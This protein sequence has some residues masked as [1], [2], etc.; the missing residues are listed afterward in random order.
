MSGDVD[1]GAVGCADHTGYG[2]PYCYT[3]DPDTCTTDMPSQAHPGAEWR[4]CASLATPTAG[5]ETQD[6]AP[7]APIAPSAT[8]D[9]TGTGMAVSWNVPFNDGGGTLDEF[10]VQWSTD[11]T[12]LDA[13]ELAQA[14]IFPAPEEQVLLL[15]SPVTNEA[16]VIRATAK[17]VNEVQTIT[18]TVNAAEDD[19]VQTITT[20]SSS[21]VAEIQTVTTSAI[22]RDEVQQVL[23]SATLLPEIQ[24]VSMVVPHRD[25]I[26]VV[27]I[28]GTDVNEV[29]AITITTT[30]GA[31]A[32][33]GTFT[34][35]L[36]SS[37]P[38][39]DVA[40]IPIAVREEGCCLCAVKQPVTGDSYSVS[41]NMGSTAAQIEAALEGLTN[42]DAVTVTNNCEPVSADCTAADP[43][44]GGPS[45][46]NVGTTHTM[47]EW[48]VTFDGAGVNGD[49]PL[50]HVQSALDGVVTDVGN[51]P[52]AVE[53]V[54]GNEIMGMVRLTLNDDIPGVQT[55][56]EKMGSSGVWP[57]DPAADG[58][59]ESIQFNTEAMSG[60]FA[61]SGT[62]MQEKLEQ[63][64]FF[65]TVTVSRLPVD[66]GDAAVYTG[67]YTFAIT[68]TYKEGNLPPMIC[69]SSSLENKNLDAG[70]P[71]PT[72]EVCTHADDLDA[73]NAHHCRNGNFANGS[74]KLTHVCRDVAVDGTAD[75]DVACNNALASVLTTVAI[76]WDASEADVKTALQAIAYTNGGLGSVAVTRTAIN[77]SPGH[78]WSGAYA[79]A[80]TYTTKEGNVKPLVVSEYLTAVTAGGCLLTNTGLTDDCNVVSV[81]TVVETRDG[82]EVAGTVV[83]TFGAE[84]TADIA[85]TADAATIRSRLEALSAIPN[86]G[87]TVTLREDGAGTDYLG[88]ARGRMW[89]V[90]F[91]DQ[92]QGGNI[93][94]MSAV[95]TFHT[96]SGQGVGAAVG[97][98]TVKQG[99][100]L[101]GNFRLNYGDFQTGDI[102]FNANVAH[103]RNAL[104]LLDAIDTV[105][106]SVVDMTDGTTQVQAYQW[107][108]TFNWDH[109]TDTTRN[110]Y[111]PACTHDVTQIHTV[112]N[113]P[114]S[115]CWPRNVGDI[116]RK[117][118]V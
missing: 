4:D 99:C 106:V 66:S 84:S 37:K 57:G 63:S 41:L 73:T 101:T 72:C 40:A 10:L 2:S 48:R 90:T 112:P 111:D 14:S 116:D 89:L 45:V 42:I 70:T 47:Y 94:Q 60:G 117:S 16:Q 78:S 27:R 17:V 36:D 107:S 51:K 20:S 3:H 110:V 95:G 88:P 105:K 87:V 24:T 81:P 109:D 8:S 46:T 98:S 108:I 13:S 26:Q 1:T 29:Q 50:L 85:V 96:A 6:R 92:A 28:S 39:G 113:R 69:D 93:D 77:S 35:A 91:T 11:P 65:G 44:T 76:P 31:A 18:T 97:V 56:A 68:F 86:G 104:Q 64:G 25:E 22:D 53:K 34:L 38:C 49:I 54:K 102:P 32:P 33:T 15:D 118:V 71:D 62:S 43:S 83:L 80:I 30:L 7:F 115:M 103:V 67:G 114:F 75:A 21:V 12:F 23:T 100:E 9:G 52:R 58:Q 61:M 59:T 55:P 79:W 19:E 5:V 82:N 74:F